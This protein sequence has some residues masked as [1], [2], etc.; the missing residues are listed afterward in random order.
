[1]FVYCLVFFD[2]MDFH[3]TTGIVTQVIRNSAR[4][5]ITFALVFFAVLI[6]FTTLGGWFMFIV[7]CF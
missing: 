3:E 1:M 4:D 7:D 5:L 6:M 2:V